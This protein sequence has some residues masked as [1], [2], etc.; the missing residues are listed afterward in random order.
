MECSI[1]LITAEC[2]HEAPCIATIPTFTGMETTTGSSQAGRSSLQSQLR[3][4]MLNPLQPLERSIALFS[5]NRVSCT[6]T[7]LF[8]SLGSNA[9]EELS[10][11]AVHHDINTLKMFLYLFF[12]IHASFCPLVVCLNGSPCIDSTIKISIFMT[13]QLNES[14]V[15]QFCT[16][17]K[18]YFSCVL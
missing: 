4:Q 8:S 11:K 2:D 18:E 6:G 17:S 16:G 9:L 14:L 1:E 5:G 13:Q 3:G 15:Y 10:G 7:L 12:M